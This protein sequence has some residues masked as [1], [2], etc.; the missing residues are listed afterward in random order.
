MIRETS[1]HE[2][3][4][5]ISSKETLPGGDLEGIRLAGKNASG[6]RTCTATFLTIG[7]MALPTCAARAGP[8]ATEI[9]QLKAAMDAL[10]PNKE[11]GTAHQSRDANL[12]RQPTP[13]S[14]ANGR[15]Q[16]SADERHDRALLDR[17]RTL[18][19]QGDER[20]CREALTAVRGGQRPR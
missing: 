2:V 7:A 1:T 14:V 4:F 16:A 5:V 8:C 18:D 10:A 13:G 15:Q 19:E 12:H 3:V 20:G 17:A 6:L 11:D 9:A